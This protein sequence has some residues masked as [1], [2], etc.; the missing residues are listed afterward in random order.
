MSKISEFL[1][2][3]SDGRIKNEKQADTVLFVIVILL[4]LASVFLILSSGSKENIEGTQYD[5][6]KG[7][8]GTELPDDY[9]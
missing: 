6:S 4:V 1:I 9:R 8:G 7:Y 2:N 3:N 5:P